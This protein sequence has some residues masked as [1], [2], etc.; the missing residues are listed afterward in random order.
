M[1]NSELS[2]P[3]DYYP[4][5]V[6]FIV[7]K[8]NTFTLTPINPLIAKLRYLFTNTFLFFGLMTVALFLPLLISHGVT[9]YYISL[10][11]GFVL[12]YFISR[13]YHK[14]TN[15]SY[16]DELAKKL[17]YHSQCSELFNFDEKLARALADTNNL[18]INSNPN[19]PILFRHLYD[20]IFRSN[21]D[22]KKRPNLKLVS[23]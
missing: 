13:I 16:M 7:T 3:Q 22:S 17:G 18:L 21:S 20:L 4:R 5:V 8:E 11:F 12:S 2:I 6:E 9:I 23:M 15:T 19:T 1:S 10:I 14:L